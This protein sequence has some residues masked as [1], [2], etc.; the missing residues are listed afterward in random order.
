MYV[1]Q[2]NILESDDYQ[3]DG[4]YTKPEE[5]Y[6]PSF[7]AGLV[8]NISTKYWLLVQVLQ[9]IPVVGL[10]MTILWAA[11]ITSEGKE[12]LVNYARG[13]IIWLVIETVLAVLFVAIM[14][15]ITWKTV[16]GIRY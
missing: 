8:E 15:F 2:D 4:E 3:E 11:G 9:A 1:Q 5:M 7:T 14:A 12:A 10:V 6:M 13:R 16:G